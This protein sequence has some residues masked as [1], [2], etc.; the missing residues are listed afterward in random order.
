MKRFMVFTYYAGRPLGGMKDYLD[1]FE[2]QEEALDNILLEHG[3]YYQVVDRDSLQ[4]LRE[5]LAVYKN[6]SPEHFSPEGPRR[7]ETP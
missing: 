2:S 4:I 3:R 5:G 7:D 6:F 1:S